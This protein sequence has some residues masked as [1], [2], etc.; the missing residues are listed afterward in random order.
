MRIVYCGYD[1]FYGCLEEL[2]KDKN[3]TIVKI[4]TF[5]T[6]N[7]YNFNDKIKS[8]ASENKIPITYDKP[9]E[10][11]LFRLFDKDKVDVIITAGYIYK[12]PIINHPNFK[13]INIHPT[14]LP[15]GRGP[16]PLPWIIL[17]NE[18]YSGVTIHRLTDDMDKGPILLQ[19][20]F[21]V[22]DNED[23]ETLSCR[24]QVL[25]KKLITEVISNFDYYYDNAKEQGEGEY[26]PY[27][28]DEDMTFNGLMKVEDIDRII[29]AF[30]KFDSCTSF[31]GKNFLV[32][33]AT[34]WKEEHKYKPN[35]IIHITNKEV[36]MAVLDGFVCI[37]Y[38]EEDKD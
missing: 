9:T 14:L 36:L 10:E 13:G 16:W 32:H 31:L 35:T 30:G 6:D 27:P 4:F 29:R 7:K 15:K 11:E 28:T 38:Y 23:L 18:E 25:A 3:N 17:K 8:I 33:D 26:Y 21:K 19:E 5:E 22:L 24:S 37:R 1:F 20:K 12:I 34:C 2:V